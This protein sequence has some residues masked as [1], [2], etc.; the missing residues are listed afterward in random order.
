MIEY[1]YFKNSYNFKYTCYDNGKNTFQVTNE[2]TGI[3]E[4]DI[5]NNDNINSRTDFYNICFDTLQQFQKIEKDF[6]KYKH[7]ENRGVLVENNNI[8][9]FSHVLNNFQKKE[10]FLKVVDKYKTCKIKV[11]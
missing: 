11:V 8:L 3:I 4:L 6:K 10:N 5:R 9:V 1:R 2:N 7:L